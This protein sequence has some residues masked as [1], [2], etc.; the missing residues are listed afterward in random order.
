MS[1][2]AYAI[3]I[4][5]SPGGGMPATIQRVVPLPPVQHQGA[6]TFIDGWLS[7]AYDDFG[8]GPPQVGV[9][10]RIFNATHGV[11]LDQTI[12]FP[13][14][15]TVVKHLDSGDLTASFQ[16]PPGGGTATSHP[17]LSALVE[18]N[19]SQSSPLPVHP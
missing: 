9:R 18:F 1:S 7:L 16:F 13:V 19:D 14:G 2:G 17:A 12:Q 6:I 15:R 3:P 11:T 10:V 4:D 5:P 8:A